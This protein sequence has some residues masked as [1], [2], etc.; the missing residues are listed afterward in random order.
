MNGEELA[1]VPPLLVGRYPNSFWQPEPPELAGGGW[2]LER[3]DVFCL[4]RAAQASTPFLWIRCGVAVEIP[5]SEAL[6]L[7][8]A[9]CNK[10]LMVGRA[11]LSCGDEIGLVAMDEVISASS[12]SWEHQPSIQELV[13]RFETTLTQAR[14]LRAEV[15]DQFGGRA[16]THDEWMHLVF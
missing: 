9:A 5:R 8:I 10:D 13:D 1:E 15:L 12:L 16:F 3:D 6:A 2:V 11:Y 14:K 7:R 4:V